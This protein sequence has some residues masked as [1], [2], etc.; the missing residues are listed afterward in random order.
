MRMFRRGLLAWGSRVMVLLV[1]VCCTVSLIYMLACTPKVDYVQSALA[2][3]SGPPGKDNYHAII[4]EHEEQQ[5]NYINSLKKQIAQLK[6]ELQQRSEQLKT[7]QE[8]GGLKLGGPFDQGSPEKTHTDLYDFLHAQIDKAEV[9]AGQKV[10]TE[11][12]V[13]PFESFTMQKVYQLEMGL[14]RHP[15]EKPVRKDKRDEMMEAVESAVESLNSAED[16]GNTKQHAYSSSDFIE[17]IYR[18]ERDKGTVYDM[19]FKG[20]KNHELNRV[21]LFRPFGPIMKVKNEKINTANMLINIIVPLSKR[22]D[23]FRQFMQMFREVCIQQDGRVYLT[24]VYFGKEQMNE[25]KDILE[26]NAKQANFKNYTFIQRNEDFSRGKGLDVGARAWKSSNVLLFFC[27]VDIYFTADFLNSCR[28]NAQP[29]KKVFYPVLFSQYNPAI[30]Y[31]HHAPA[32]SLEQQLVIKK[33]TGFW[34]DFGFGMTCQY[35]SD[36]I[37]IGGFDL[38]IKG[39]GGEDVHL[40]RKYLHSNLIVIRTPVRG[41]FHLWHEKHCV[42]ELT[43]EQYKMCMQSK[44]MNEASHGQLG[45][46]VF[47]HEIEAHLRKQK[48]KMTA[49]KT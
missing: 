1:F 17:G 16:E 26:I 43:P 34:R 31:G 48:L 20:E 6:E 12:A 32:P 15:E 39:W 8:Q 29:G 3:V 28:M 42:D 44:A 47:R 36:F 9:H 2:K 19:T 24:V 25:I 37:N 7:L 49:K 33:D 38:D 23:K 10:P 21:V 14:T 27:D 41:L 18:T 11:Y 46:L 45:M 13:V 40:Y 35:R 30:I 4:Q 5:N 22:A